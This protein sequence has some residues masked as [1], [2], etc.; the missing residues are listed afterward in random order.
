MPAE[1][2]PERPRITLVAPYWDFWEASVPYDLRAD[3]DAL[4]GRAAEALDADVV[5]E[6]EAEATLVLQTMATPPAATLD[7]LGPQPLVVWALTSG[8]RVPDTLDHGGIT[9]AGAT[10]GTPMLTSVLVREGRPFQL[11]AGALEDTATVRA[12]DE[13]LRAAATAARLGRARIGR[14]G[15]PLA[16]Y[17]CVDADDERLRVETGIELV[18]VEPGEVRDLYRAVEPARVRALEQE[19]R[20]LYEVEVEGDGLERSLRAACALEDLVA[21]HRLD[22]GAL[23]CHVPE[24]RLGAEI[25]IAPCFGL[26]RLTSRGVPWTCVGDVLTAVAMLTAKLLG[27]SAQY[28]ELELLDHE[29][30]ELV[31]AS[32][33]EHDLALVPAARPRLI[34]NGWFARDERRG[35]CACFAAA[36]GPATLVGFAELASGYR[37]IAAEGELTGRAWP[38]VGTANGAFRF[39]TSPALEAWSSW[40]RAGANHHSALARG[41]LAGGVETVARFL[42]IDVVRV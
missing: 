14:V 1:G 42:G 2:A 18:P 37:L 3:R 17:L 15:R 24:I 20:E 33:G 8:G 7:R 5:E 38:G 41:L 4:A 22:A 21:R 19:T 39:H 26:G 28:H 12:V 35:A 6:P 34:E 23:N 36:P 13:A 11:V 29:T 9:S 10:V 31:V 27:G 32:S 25:G 30:G 16:G 40:C